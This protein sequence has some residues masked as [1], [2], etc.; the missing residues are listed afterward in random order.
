MLH[1]YFSYE[2]LRRLQDNILSLNVTSW[3]FI[4]YLGLHWALNF[5]VKEF[6]KITVQKYT[7][8]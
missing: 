2:Y 6:W 8:E 4:F 3:R 1:S 5:K 7:D